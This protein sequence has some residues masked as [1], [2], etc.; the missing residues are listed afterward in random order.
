M[1]KITGTIKK[2]NNIETFKDF[3]KRTFWIEDVSDKFPNTYQL[4]LWKADCPMIDKY[5]VDDIITAYIDLKGRY[6]K[7]EDREGVLN[8]L[9][10]W[11]IEKDGVFE[12]EIN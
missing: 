10:C 3:D 12:K 5:K 1:I 9:K 8:T 4:E 11:N 7:K 6:W 2:I